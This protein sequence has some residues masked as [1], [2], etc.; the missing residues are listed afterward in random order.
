VHRE[1]Q[2]WG[3]SRNWQKAKQQPKHIYSLNPHLM[4]GPLTR[5]KPEPDSRFADTYPQSAFWTKD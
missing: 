1:T 4:F 3:D 5:H 2:L